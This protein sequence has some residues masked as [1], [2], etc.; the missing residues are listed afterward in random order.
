MW[1]KAEKE[2]EALLK[3]AKVHSDPL[4]EEYLGQIGDRLMPEHVRTA[5]GPGLKFGVI[6]DPTLNAFAMP[7]GKIYVHTGLLSRLDNEAQLA[8]II[9]HEMTHV[10]HRHALRF[11]RDAQTK[12]ILY[13]IAAIGLSIGV[14]AAAGSRAKSGDPV[15][16]AVISQTANAVLGLGLQLAAIASIT[17]Y[18]R[19][20]ER[21]ADGQGMDMLVKAGYDPKQA[22]K[23]FELLKSEAGDRGALETFFFGTHPRLQERIDSTKELIA[24]RYASAAAR[25]DVTKD[26]EDFAMRMRTVVRENA[27]LD[28]KAGRY[29]L[30]QRQL[31]RVLALTPRDPVANVYYGDLHRLQAQRSRNLNDRAVQTREALARYERAAE[32]DP[33]LPDPFRQMGLLYYQQ[34]EPERAKVAFEKYLALKPDAPDARRI[35]EY[36][37]E[38]DR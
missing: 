32:L 19:D 13:T 14:A 4:L 27:A 36:I 6:S 34:K 18:G 11:Q 22:P 35:K 31:D 33:K 3:K 17:G 8:T 37:L 12:Q 38:L 5:G 26:T 2:E 20:L 10:T 24:T 7:N 15:G 30:A 23:V 28:I 25:P 1:A 21:E 16:A 29:E 9:G